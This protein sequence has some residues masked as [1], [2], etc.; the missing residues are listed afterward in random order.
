MTDIY[1]RNFDSK[2]KDPIL[3]SRYYLYRKVQDFIS[4]AIKDSECFRV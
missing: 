2:F 1:Q 4:E 3:D